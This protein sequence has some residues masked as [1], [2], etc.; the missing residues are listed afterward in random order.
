M[1]KKQATLAMRENINIMCFIR[2]DKMFPC[3]DEI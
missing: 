3:L 1:H 2:N